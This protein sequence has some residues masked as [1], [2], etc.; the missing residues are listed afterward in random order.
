MPPPSPPPPPPPSPPRAALAA[1]LAP[2]P[3]RENL[4]LTE[5]VI[6][7]VGVHSSVGGGKSDPPRPFALS[8]N[9]SDD[10]ILSFVSEGEGTL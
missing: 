8:T 3:P 6:D 4:S 9:V 2:P 10:G 5:G 1:A 7:I